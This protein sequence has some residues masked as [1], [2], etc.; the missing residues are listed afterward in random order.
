[1]DEGNHPVIRVRAN[2]HSHGVIIEGMIPLICIFCKYVAYI[3]FDLDLH[4]YQNHRI[5]LIKLP[6]GTGSLDTRINYAIQEG[7]RVGINLRGLNKEAK[8]K[9]GLST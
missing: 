4:L 1:M 8:H 7:R 3:E 6:I 5:D 2:G 9:L